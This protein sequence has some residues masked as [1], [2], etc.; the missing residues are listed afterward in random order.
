[1]YTPDQGYGIVVCYVDGMTDAMT[2][3]WWCD[4]DVIIYPSFLLP[5]L[6]HYDSASD[7]TVSRTKVFSAC[8]VAQL[9]SPFHADLCHTIRIARKLEIPKELRRRATARKGPFGWGLLTQERPPYPTPKPAWYHIPDINHF[10]QNT[11]NLPG[12]NHLVEIPLW[13]QVLTIL[14]TDTTK[15]PGIPILHKYH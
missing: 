13:Y 6:S 12:I 2:M 5:R 4:D 15:V 11:T 3:L 1:M 7:P 9:S 8:F 14:C 10:A